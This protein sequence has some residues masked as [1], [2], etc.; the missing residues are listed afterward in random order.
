MLGSFCLI[1]WRSI[2]SLSSL[3]A[4]PASGSLE[5]SLLLQ[6]LTVW[7]IGYAPLLLVR[8][9]PG[10]ILPSGLFLALS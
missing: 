7:Y 8:G 3:L 2:A 9:L 1:C 6:I 4:L 10:A 5:S